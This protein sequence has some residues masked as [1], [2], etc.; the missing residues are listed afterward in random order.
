MG[1]YLTFL[2]DGLY[3]TEIRKN[4]PKNTRYEQNYKNS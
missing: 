3:M 2:L 4:F 1:I